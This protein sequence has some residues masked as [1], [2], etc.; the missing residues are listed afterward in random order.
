MIDNR[1]GK[2]IEIPIKNDTIEAMK[3]FDLKVNGPGLRLYDPGYTNTCVAT[4]RICEIQGGKGILRYRGYPIEQ[5]AEKSSFLEVSFLLLYGELPSAEQL[6]YFSNRVM[7]HT[8]VHEDLKKLMTSF[9]YDAHPM[10]NQPSIHHYTTRQSIMLTTSLLSSPSIFSSRHG[11][12]YNCC[13][14]HFSS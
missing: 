11:Y 1:T 8:F 12:F 6:N 3:F 13:Y 5:L 14:G 2:R 7:K 9:R 4:S 10:G